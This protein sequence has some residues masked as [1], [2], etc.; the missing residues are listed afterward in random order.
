[1]NEDASDEIGSG[2]SLTNS[3]V[4]VIDD[5]DEDRGRPVEKG[6]CAGDVGNEALNEVENVAV[7]TSTSVVL[8]FI[9]LVGLIN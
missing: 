1:M 6:G 4:F 3:E 9:V 5:D 2:N 7:G 8:D